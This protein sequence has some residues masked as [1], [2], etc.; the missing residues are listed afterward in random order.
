MCVVVVVVEVVTKS[1]I[2][3]DKVRITFKSYKNRIK[4]IAYFR[5]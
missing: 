2:L 4:V 3:L 5:F 1:Q